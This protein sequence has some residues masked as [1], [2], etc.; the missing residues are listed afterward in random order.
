[1]IPEVSLFERGR[2]FESPDAIGALSLTPPPANLDTGSNHASGWRGI[3][4]E[5]ILS[6]KCKQN[7]YYQVL[8]FFGQI[9]YNGYYI[10]FKL[11]ILYTN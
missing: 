5:A 6:T 1:M 8:I 4:G 11:Y 3:R 9:V 10:V 2:G 7:H